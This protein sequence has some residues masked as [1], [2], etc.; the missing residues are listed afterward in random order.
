MGNFQREIGVLF[1]QQ[2]R[3]TL[4]NDCKLPIRQNQCFI[5]RFWP[6][7]TLFV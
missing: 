2:D 1:D 3:Q 5:A 6:P 4:T 7:L